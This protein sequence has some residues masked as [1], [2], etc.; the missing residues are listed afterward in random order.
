MAEVVLVC[1][2]FALAAFFWILGADWFLWRMCDVVRRVVR[3]QR[4]SEDAET[5]A[6]RFRNAADEGLRDRDAR[7]R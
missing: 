7:R 2:F 3:A 4:G 5:W 6:A 1:C